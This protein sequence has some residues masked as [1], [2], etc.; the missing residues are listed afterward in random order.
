MQYLMQP[1][2]EYQEAWLGDALDLLHRWR[3]TRMI[4]LRWGVQVELELFG[5]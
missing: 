1:D 3:Q 4:V 2:L 5:E